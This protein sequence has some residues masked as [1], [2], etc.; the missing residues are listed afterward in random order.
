MKKCIPVLLFLLASAIPSFAR[1][2][3]NGIE[4]NNP[5]FTYI[6]ET[7]GKPAGFDVDALNWISR[8]MGFE[9]KHMPV[10]WD[11][12]IPTLLAQKID[13]ICSGMSISP[14]R[15]RLVS[16]SN[17]Y[18]Q[19]Y[20]VFVVKQDS[21]LTVAALL[22]EK[23]K[24]G[25]QRGTS[26]ATA[27]VKMQK[28]KQLRFEVRLYDSG[29]LMIEDVIKGRIH[30]ALMDFQ[31]ARDAVASGKPIKIAGVHGDPVSY[32]VALRKDDTELLK[33]VNEGY[34]KLMADPVWQQLQQKYNVQPLH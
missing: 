10:A 23:L 5:P 28:E 24:L 27:L 1:S 26:E 17:P 19:M 14:E 6:D 20:N 25:G 7:S 22:S 32:G 2:Y 18:W 21:D 9:V 30:A 31:P 8:T 29:F 3:I 33:L 34:K 11:A 13:M 4:A 12:I 15:A 16:F